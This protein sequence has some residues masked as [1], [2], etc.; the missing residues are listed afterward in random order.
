[1]SLASP[2]RYTAKSPERTAISP[3]DF[4]FTR[5]VAATA[6]SLAGF[7]AVPLRAQRVRPVNRI[8]AP[9]DESS[10]VTLRGTVHPLANAA[11]DRGPAADDMQLQRVQLLLRR[12]PAQ[13]AS[14]EQLI[15]SMHTPGSTDYHKWLTPQQFGERFGPSDQDIATIESWLGS[16]GLQVKGVDPSKQVLEFS[17]SVAQMR[18]A[19]HTQIHKYDVHGETHYANANDP[20]IVSALAPVI[21]GFVSLNNFRLKSYAHVLGHA[22]YDTQ[23]H[24]AT[25]EWTYGAG[26]NVS[27][28]L[29]PG[30]FAKQYDLGPLYAAGV[31]GS[32]QT[33]AV[34]GDANINV[35]LVNQFRST[36]GLAPNPPQV[37]I[38]GN[39]PGID[40][41]NN[42]DGPNF[43]STEAYLDVEWSGAVAPAATIDFVIAANT[44]LESGLILAAEHAVFSDIAPVISLSFGFCEAGLGSTNMFLSQLWQQAAAQGITVLVSSGDSGS[45]GC[46]SDL[47]EYYAIN[48]L[49]VNGY[50]STPYNVSVGGTD[51]FYSD[52]NNAAALA[53]QLA[54]FWNATPSQLPQASLLQVI[55]E[56]PWNDSQY[57]LDIFNYYTDISGSTATTIAGGGGGASSCESGT[58]SSASGGWAACTGGYAKPS[59][60]TGSGV[61]ADGVRDLPD[62]SLFAADGLNESFYP[63]CAADG[64]CQPPSG[65]NLIQIT[66]VGGTSA[67]VQA[68]AGIMALVNQ[69]YGRQGQ[70]D[71]VLYPLKAQFPATFHDVIQGSNSV[72]CGFSPTTPNCIA[73]T[74]PLTV[75][76]PTNGNAVEGQL[77]TGTTADY[78]AAAGYNLATGL[79]SID[80]NVLVTDWGSIKFNSTTVSLTSPTA[81]TTITHGASV[82]FSGSISGSGTPTGDVAIETDSTEP[83]NQGQ[84]TFALSSGSFNGSISYLPGGSYNVWVR[85]GGDGTNAASTSSKVAITVNPEASTTYFNILDSATAST[86]SAAISSG[87]TN[88]PYGTQL[89]LSAEPVPTTYYNQC[90][91]PSNPPSSCQSILYTL[92]TGTVTFADNSTNINTAVI[93]SEGDAEYNA[94]WNVGN[95]SVTAHYSGDASYNSSSASAITFSIVKDTPE[96]TL[97]S[98]AQGLSGNF[99]GGQSTVFTIQVE[100]TANLTNENTYGV[101]YSNPTA[102]PTGTITVSGFPS[103]VPTS[104]T[105][106]AAVDPTTTSADGVATIIAPP[107]T[108]AGTYN[109]AISYGG[110]SNYTSTS[111]SQTVTIAAATGLASTTSASMSGSISATS[112]ITVTGTVTGQTGKAAPTGDVLIS[113]SGFSLGEIPVTPGAGDT[114]TFS[115]TLNSQVLSQGANLITIQYLGDS[116]YA[117]SSTTLTVNNP[118][119]DFSIVPQAAIIPLSAG[120]GASDTVNVSS[121][122]GF[123]GTIS[124]TCGAPAGITCQAPASVMLSSGGSTMITLNISA[125]TSAVNGNNTILLTGTSGIF[126]HT[127]AIRAFV[128]GGITVTGSAQMSVQPGSLNFSAEPLSFS[129]S[130]QT[131]TLSNSGTGSFTSITIST[132]GEFSQTNNC[133][134]TVAGTTSCSIN[135]TSMPTT[136]GSQNGVLTISGNAGG[137]TGIVQLQVSLYGY[138]TNGFVLPTAGMR[139]VPVTPCRV[140]D[141]RNANGA[142]GG[143]AIAAGTS[144][145]FVIPSSACGIPATATAYSLNVAVVPGGPLGYLTVWPTGQQQPLVASTN[146]VDGRVKSTAAIVPAG[147]SGAISVYATNATNVVLD[148]NGY[149][150]PATTTGA[151]AFYPVTPCRVVD[152]RNAPGPLAGPSLAGNTSRSFPILSSACGIP[153][154]AQAYS[155]NFAAVPKVPL[156]YLTAWPAGQSQPLVA[157]LN[158]VTGTVTANAAIVP[159]GTSGAIEV[160]ASNDTDLVIDINGYFAPPAT[161]GLS[162]YVLP[163]CR[164]LDTRQPSGSLPFNG[165]KNV[166]VAGACG[167]PAPGQAYVF[168][169]TVVPP[170]ALG[171]LTMWPEG[172]TQPLVATLN[173]V[174][175]AV[176]NNMAIV[177]TNNG[178]ISAYAS[179]PT[180]LVLDIFGYFGP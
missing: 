86:G 79:G 7:T 30:D 45:A 46:D 142:F 105:L 165:V 144:R 178:S 59:W 177:P 71:F 83:A 84:T 107:G 17:G 103:G 129:S 14:L 21:A 166:T 151:L 85:Y 56:Q 167:V 12:S 110:D 147:A 67:A 50:G 81:G 162:L 114:S 120:G 35:D 18:E 70:A 148:I 157:T 115:E 146:S 33:I 36:F 74:S 64:D 93:N 24:T 136:P 69:K 161:G 22:I 155:L 54:T 172:T 111:L 118:L 112:S 88:I 163:P 96:I 152:T 91:A 171:Y 89:I 25:P 176:T 76:D 106:A 41:I 1:L 133:G 63:L 78:K 61:P 29:S 141:T 31:N 168:N 113:S 75:T 90:I 55:P 127:A 159:A 143:P 95:H 43:D 68:F 173:A 122:N 132:S 28:P 154:T 66:G 47:T 57:G 77:G 32:G 8:T 108:A 130:P 102:A 125:T 179:N 116:T 65:N 160:F 123:S 126:I 16:H 169:A 26:A 6:L 124:F 73:V 101:G 137:S 37:I 135:V 52:Y 2:S 150:V 170:G 42:P 134:T 98:T 80:A 38:D 27:Y 164:V 87:Q 60:Q 149:F 9:I 20:Q 139:Y 140:A 158:A 53:G 119:A 175:G 121:T 13:E 97:S 5:L 72:P 10:R 153:S 3:A 92:P 19:F 15:T 44:A 51:F 40:G 156:G 99:A 62:V 23:K 138:G 104:A 39:D 174:D 34:L 49:A 4:R 109:V 128:T 94:P 117:E 131:V 58:G 100:N 145:D 48:G 11:N 180:H 82:T